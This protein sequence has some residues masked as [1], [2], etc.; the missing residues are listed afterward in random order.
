M[1]SKRKA[2]GR[3]I[4]ALL[5]ILLVLPVFASCAKDTPQ[6]SEPPSSVS[7]P[8]QSLPEP[9]PQEPTLEPLPLAQGVNALTGQPLPEGAAENQRPVAVMVPN[10]LRALPQR[11]LAQADLMYEMLTEGGITRLMAV[12]RS[13]DAVPAVGP[14]RSTRD[15]FVQF[16]VPLNA[17]HVHIGSSVYA[18]NLLN[19][20]A[21]Q[22]VDGIYLGNSAFVFDT[23]R[24]LPR[25]S[26]M[27][28]ENCWYTDAGLLAQGMEL[29]GV[30]AGGE[31]Q[32]VFRFT[33]KPREESVDAEW[34]NYTYSESSLSG[35]GYDPETGLYTKTIFGNY[36]T[37]EDGTP[38]TFKNV[39]LLL[40]D[41][42]LKPDGQCTEFDLNE[43]R[44]YYFTEGGVQKILWQKGDPT[45]ALRVTDEAGE[46]LLV[47][48]GKSFVG[49]LPLEREGS[50]VYH[51]SPQTQEAMAAQQAASAEPPVSA[52]ESPEAG[53][54]DETAPVE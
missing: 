29:S 54:P 17:I 35:F 33:E 3:R 1:G 48:Q 39:F 2:G 8:V 45:Q 6:S 9:E 34:I 23:N 16:A 7:Q 32:T 5:A 13:A 26:G 38:Y 10:N 24:T 12:Y 49:L 43:G 46:E 22:D 4:A 37:D 42:T 36:H 18:R 28:N 53:T 14:V 25:T 51:P 19:V 27:L 44:G 52:G 15:Q 21:Y 30:Q 47:Q 40:C 50:L 41:I 31:V 20:L 11:G